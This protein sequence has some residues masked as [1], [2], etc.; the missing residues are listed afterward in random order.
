[1]EVRLASQSSFL[2]FPVCL[3]TLSPSFLI[4]DMGIILQETAVMRITQERKVPRTEFGTYL[5]ATRQGG[6][7]EGVGLV[8][9]PHLQTSIEILALGRQR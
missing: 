1:M 3:G 9:G 4:Y 5:L 8:N 7:H 6:A 2:L